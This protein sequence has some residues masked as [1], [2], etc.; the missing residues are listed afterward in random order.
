M[1][2]TNERRKMNRE[3]SMVEGYAVYGRW[4]KRTVPCLITEH[5]GRGAR[6]WTNS[7]TKLPEKFRLYVG[8]NDEAGRDVVNVWRKGVEHGVAFQPES[9]GR[10]FLNFTL[11][12][13][14]A[15]TA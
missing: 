2:D 9:P 14:G 3:P 5:S 15:R 10:A 4:F 12:L 11:N 1:T 6:L 8:P 13:R 7:L